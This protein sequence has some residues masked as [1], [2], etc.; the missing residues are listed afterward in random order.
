MFHF[1][2]SSTA[3]IGFFSFTPTYIKFFARPVYRDSSVYIYKGTEKHIANPP[4]HWQ[5]RVVLILET[6]REVLIA[7]SRHQTINQVHGSCVHG[8]P[9]HQGHVQLPIVQLLL[10]VF[11]CLLHSCPFFLPRG[12]AP[13]HKEHP[14][15][16]IYAPGGGVSHLQ[17]LLGFDR[18]ID[19]S[20]EDLSFRVEK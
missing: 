3:A 4:P 9:S 15:Q 13:A 8:D 6:G 19:D 17:S 11:S 1:I 16:D 10:S 2:S 14:T 20:P 7:A 5:K 12:A 18:V